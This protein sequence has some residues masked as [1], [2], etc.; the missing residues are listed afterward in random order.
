MTAPHLDAVSTLWFC[1]VGIGTTVITLRRVALG[2][3]VLVMADPF[4]FARYAGGTTITSFKVAL[5]GVFIALILRGHVALPRSTAVRATVLILLSLIAATAATVPEA[6]FRSAA[7]RE[8]FKAAEY[9]FVFLAAWWCSRVDRGAQS[10]LG[11]AAALAVLVVSVNAWHDF[12]VPRSGVLIDGITVTRIAGF[13]EGPNQLASWLGIALPAAV[14][15]C[16]VEILLGFAI[17]LGVAALVLTLSRAGIAQAAVALA[18]AIAV[19]R[20]SVRRYAALILVAM[21]LA[22]GTLMVTKNLSGAILYSK[23]IVPSVDPGGTGS[24]QILWTSALAM[25]RA[26]PLLGVGAGNFELLLSAYGAPQRVRT[27]ANSLYLEALADGGI[28][29]LVPTLIA[30]V[31][32]PLLLIFRRRASVFS[33]AIGITGLALAAH[34]I[35]DDVTFYTKVGQLWWVVAAVALAQVDDANA[36][37]TRKPGVA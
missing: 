32:P 27:H 1:L 2:P 5:L 7:L 13:L 35:L 15:A 37:R 6:P 25:A 9:A 21:S 10:F 16:D 34:G 20:A 3:A 17:V 18:G 31:L 36:C 22:L 24:R 33:V 23:T 14:A 12:V 8:T 19:R 4:A 30:A 28:V 11:T 29:L 26:H